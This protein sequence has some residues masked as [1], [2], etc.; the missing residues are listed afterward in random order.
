MN[1]IK[2]KYTYVLKSIKKHKFLKPKL[3]DLSGKTYVISGGSR[4]IGLSIGKHLASLGANI[5]L[6]GKTNEPHPKLEGTIHT[7]CNEVLMAGNE[8]SKALGLVCDIRDPKSIDSA[9]NSIVK[10]FGS[11]D[12]AVLNA[13]ALC[14]NPTL[15]QTD[16]E[17]DLMTGVNIN[18]TFRVGQRCLEHINKSDHGSILLIS[19][20]IEML[21]E[22]D[23]WVNHL[24]YSM[25]KFNMSLIGKFWDKEFPNVGV[26]T[27]WPRTTLNTAPVRNIL[28]GD[29]MAQI[30][31]SPDIM[32]EAAKHIICADPEVCTGK[33]LIDDEVLSS[34]DIPLEQYKVNKDLPDKEL[35]PDFFC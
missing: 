21:Y 22:D 1:A 35:M 13:S 27:L 3:T 6:L 10:E 16:K 25:S 8:N 4:G 11:I 31:R 26:N 19:P 34:L 28:G 20:P 15:K 24:Y 23:W 12:G 9:V 7:A 30:S 33:N 18:G 2:N 32:G 29:A 5:A 14:L 17:V